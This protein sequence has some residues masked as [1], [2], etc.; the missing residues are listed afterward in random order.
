MSTAPRQSA[1]TRVTG[2]RA[3]DGPTAPPALVEIVDATVAL[4]GRTVWS[5]VSATIAPGEFVAILGP[6]GVGKSTLLK[7]VLRPV[8]PAP[9]P[10]RRPG[11]PPRPGRGPAGPGRSCSRSRWTAWTC[12]TRPGWPR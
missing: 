4:G 5:G 10:V 2:A 3:P 1:A 8:P 9:G 12:P 6:N 11:P 7:A